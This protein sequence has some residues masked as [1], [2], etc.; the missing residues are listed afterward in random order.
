MFRRRLVGFASDD[1]F[2]AV[3]PCL[4]A[5]LVED[6]VAAL[7]VVS[8]SGMHFHGFAVF[9]HLALCSR[10]LPECLRYRNKLWKSFYIPQERVQQDRVTDRCV[11]VLQIMVKLEVIQLVRFTVAQLWHSV[12]QIMAKMW[13]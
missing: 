3:F 4:S 10:R 12:P 7:V 2:R 6:G 13:R 5:F 1:A 9:S 8:G 11:P